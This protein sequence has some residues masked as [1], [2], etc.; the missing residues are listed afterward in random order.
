MALAHSCLSKMRLAEVRMAMGA[1]FKGRVLSS[2]AGCCAALCVFLGLGMQQD[3]GQ[4]WLHQKKK[5]KA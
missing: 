2:R 5:K 1:H 4:C 3:L